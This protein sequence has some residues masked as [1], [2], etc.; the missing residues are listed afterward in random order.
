MTMAKNQTDESF[1]TYFV[2]E[3]FILRATGNQN[4]QKRLIHELEMNIIQ[5]KKP[6]K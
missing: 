4:N 3:V 2:K 1:L 5:D 6:D